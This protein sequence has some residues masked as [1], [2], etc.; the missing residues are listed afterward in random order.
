MSIP[1][2]LDKAGMYFNKNNPF[3]EFKLPDG[4]TFLANLTSKLN[5][6]LSDANNRRVRN[7]GFCEDYIDTNDRVKYNIV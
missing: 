2:F 6:L 7:I 1:Q 3:V 5:D 4:T